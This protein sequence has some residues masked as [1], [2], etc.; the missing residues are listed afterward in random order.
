M[1]TIQIDDLIVTIPS[2]RLQ[3]GSLSAAIMLNL[4]E[5]AERYHRTAEISKTVRLYM[6]PDGTLST[7]PVQAWWLLA[8]VE[9]PPAEYRIEAQAG[10][11]VISYTPE[12]VERG[13]GA[14][15]IITLAAN[16]SISRVGFPWAPYIS[17]AQYA[18]T[19]GVITWVDGAPEAGETYIVEIR[20]ETPTT[21]AIR[22]LLPINMAAATITLFELPEIEP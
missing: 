15:D 9:L 7:D 19:D 21:Q 4:G 2:M 11:P 6:M 16:E 8:E 14:T 3:D 5:F 13:N 1:S 10:D 17:P 20:T 22:T 12:G 18:E